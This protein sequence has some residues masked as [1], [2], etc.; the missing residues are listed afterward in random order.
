MPEDV[1][2]RF[3]VR[4]LRILDEDGNCD[5]QLKPDLDEKRIKEIFELMILARTFDE[6]ALKLQREGRIGTY[7]SIRGQE[8]AQVGSAYSLRNSDWMFPGFRENA[9]YIVRGMPIEMLF[10]YWGGDER[11]NKIPD[12][13][14]AFTVSIPVSTQIPHAVGYAWGAKLKGDKKAVIVYFGDGG[15]SEG[16]FHEGMNFAGVFKLPIVFLCENNQWAI[17]VPRTRQC[18]AETLAQKAL[19]YGFDGIQVDGNDVFA[20]YKATKQALE[21]AY[22]G[23]GPTMIECV[24]YRMSDHTTSDDSSRYRDSKE[25]QDWVKKDP[26]E[27]MRKYMKKANIWSEDYEKTIQLA[28]SEKVS[29]AIEKAE[30]ISVPSPVDM[31]TS[32]Y[33]EMPPRLKEE[34]EYFS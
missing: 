31:F 4:L 11:G 5:M 2:K 19:G 21:K 6:M 8:A 16:D 32:T 10:E 30:S 9:A 12:N 7:A 34:L 25:L 17:S 33:G 13:I 22:Q 20:V 24:T 26:I 27:R 28:A 23:N 18:G 3:E 14:N 29:K 15:T 1:V